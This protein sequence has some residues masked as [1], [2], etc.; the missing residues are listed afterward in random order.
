MSSPYDQPQPVL[1][2]VTDRGEKILLRPAE[3]RDVDA[4]FAACTDPESQRWTTL[5][6]AYDRDRAVGF[7]TDYAPGWW[8]REQ[9]ATWV[10]TDAAG[11]YAAQIDLRVLAADPKIADVG[12]LTGPDARGK[13]Y[14]TAALRTAAAYGLL[15]LGLE[16]VEWKA[17]VG[18][19]ASR[20]V[21]E[22]AGFTFEGTLRAYGSKDGRRVDE[23]IASLL[24]ADLPVDATV[25]VIA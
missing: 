15:H 6:A 13:G 12:F 4:I 9:G 21:A 14:M 1:G 10:V 3:M 18:N 24:P 2:A 19:V 16:R 20:R 17:H 22:K 8:A 25:E 7:V 5:S 11:A 23:W